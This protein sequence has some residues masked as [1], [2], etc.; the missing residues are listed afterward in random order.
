MASRPKIETSIPKAVAPPSS[1]YWAAR[2]NERK[3][4]E[5]ALRE[6]HAN[7]SRRMDQQSTQLDVLSETLRKE[8]VE[9]KS[10]ETLLQRI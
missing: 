3:Q 5:E 6:D 1:A 10:L 9:R 8:S 4:A 2:L 7:L